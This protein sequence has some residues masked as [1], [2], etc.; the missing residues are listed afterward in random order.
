MVCAPSGANTLTN[1]TMRAYVRDARTGMVSR[2]PEGD[3]IATAVSHQCI[4]FL[5]FQV[6]IQG[7]FRIMWSSAGTTASAG[8]TVDVYYRGWKS[9]K[10]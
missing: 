9:N 3:L 4:T 10:F 2:M 6:I 7:N 8:T 5:A 1:V